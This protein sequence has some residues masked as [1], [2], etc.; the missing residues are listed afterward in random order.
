LNHGVSVFNGH[1]FQNYEV[2]GG[3]SKPDSLSGP[4]GERIFHITVCPQLKSE[5]VFTDSLT[6]KQS[7]LSGSVWMCTSA[8]LSIYFPSTDS[9]SYLTRADGLPSDQANSLAF[10]GDGTA[11]LG[12]QCDGI[13]IADSSDGYKSWRTITGP[14]V[15]PSTPSGDGLPT[16]LIN[17]L[18]VAADGTVYAATDTGLAWSRDRGRTWQCSI[19][20]DRAFLSTG[21]RN[22]PARSEQPGTPAGPNGGQCT[23]LAEDVDHHLWVGHRGGI[24]ERFDENMRAT[25]RSVTQPSYLTAIL[26]RSSGIIAG[27]YGD[28]LLPLPGAK[29][30]PRMVL[31]L[32]RRLFAKLPSSGTSPQ[33]GELREL[34]PGHSGRTEGDPATPQVVALADDWQTEG[35]WIGR[36]GKNM[37]ILCAM[38]GVGEGDYVS[39]GTTNQFAYFAQIGPSSSDGDYLRYFRRSA[40]TGDPKSLEMPDPLPA[41]AAHGTSPALALRRQQAEWDDHGESYPMGQSG[42]DIFCALEIPNGAFML[43]LYAVNKDGHAGKDRFRDYELRFWDTS[44]LPL[45]DAE[46]VAGCTLLAH[47]RML[48]FW[49]GVYKRVA[50]K[51]PGR[52]TIQI[53]RNHSFNTLLSA[54]MLDHIT[55]DQELEGLGPGTAL[56]V[57]SK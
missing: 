9:W 12:T 37:A 5:A 10:G 7:A 3:L 29:A 19:G 50:V 43:S 52:I 27:S 22:A 6:G 53:C 45:T 28:G 38:G 49:G 21:S 56:D 1:K 18:L 54:I 32:A 11:Y 24:P 55:K 33:K 31:P 41:L 46:D 14:D 8:G 57:S 17:D 20:T 25:G 26:Q 42:P 47:S 13:A 35:S 23:C 2:V 15:E 48:H 30:V 34:L 40:Y 39:G 16:N 44:D 36:Y 51:G 4:I